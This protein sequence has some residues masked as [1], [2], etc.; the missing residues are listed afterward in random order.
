MGD[1]GSTQV[2]GIYKLL[3]VAK[4]QPTDFD[5]SATP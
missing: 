4:F 1:S 2:E 5:L 3:W